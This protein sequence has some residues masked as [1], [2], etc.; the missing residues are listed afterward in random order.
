[1]CVFARDKAGGHARRQRRVAAWTFVI[2]LVGIFVLPLGSYV[3]TGLLS[4]QAAAEKQSNP[5]ANYWRAVRDGVSGYTAVQGPETN[6]LIQNGGQ[7]W[8]QA[9]NGP[10]ASIMPWI[11]AVTVGALILVFLYR[12]QIKLEKQPSGKTVAR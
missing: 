2:V 8:R 11:L 3:Y 5:R 4:A 9:R 10:V 7:N 12:G 1:M 6:V